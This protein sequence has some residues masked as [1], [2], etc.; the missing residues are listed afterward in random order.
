MSKRIIGDD[1]ARFWSYVDKTDTCWLWTGATNSDGYGHIKIASKLIK[2]HR[3]ALQLH[4]VELIEGLVCDHLCRVRN[5]V[6]PDHLEQVTNEDNLRRGAAGA[7][8][9]EKTHCPQ[10]HPYDES[11]TYNYLNKPRRQCR[12]CGRVQLRARRNAVSRLSIVQ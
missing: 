7:Y 6:R 12:E 5:C 2:A 9:L 3:Y 4:S 10:G 1:V 11:N 8:Q